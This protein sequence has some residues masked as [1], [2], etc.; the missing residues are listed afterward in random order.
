MYGQKGGVVLSPRT[1]RPKSDNP[2]NIRLEVRLD[3]HMADTLQ[4]CAEKMNVTKSE[5]I[6]R[7]IIAVKEG[8]EK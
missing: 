5:V 6:I 8:L 7:G 2:K 3:K 1:G 4:E